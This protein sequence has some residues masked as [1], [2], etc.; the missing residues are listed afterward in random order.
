[1]RVAMVT[2]MKA[3]N[4]SIKVLV[5]AETDA[6]SYDGMNEIL[7]QAHKNGFPCTD[8]SVIDWAYVPAPR[9]PDIL[10]TIHYDPNTYK[11]GSFLEAI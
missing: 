6:Q 11:E 3:K 7:R 4:V 2:I 1:M 10:R 8:G 5:H 9:R